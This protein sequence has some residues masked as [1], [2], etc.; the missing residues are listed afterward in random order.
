MVTAPARRALVREIV[1]RGLSER[2]ALA[3]LRMTA[4]ALR[5]AS[6]PDRNAE[7]LE[8]IQALAGRHK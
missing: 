6:R 4:S 5:Y 7:L 1:E 2:R 8:V 3:V